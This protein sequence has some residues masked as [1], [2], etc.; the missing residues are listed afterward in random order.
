VSILHE[1]PRLK[2]RLKHA[3]NAIGHHTANWVPVVLYREAFNFV[4]RLGP[5]SLDVLE[6]SRR[7]RVARK[8]VFPILFADELEFDICK[9]TV[10]RRF[11][12]II[13]DLFEHLERPV[14][15]ARM[16]IP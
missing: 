16:P 6:I 2:T 7:P 15:A 3:L 1:R 5:R 9:H 14:R 8:V 11:D 13:A 12:L 4:E 10:E